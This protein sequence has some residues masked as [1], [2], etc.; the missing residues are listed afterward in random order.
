MPGRATV[1]A[2]LVTAL[3][4]VAVILLRAPSWATSHRQSR[5]EQPIKLRTLLIVNTTSD[6]ANPADGTCSLRGAITTS[7]DAGG[8]TNNC[9]TG[10]GFDTIHFNF[11]GKITLGSALP[12]ITQNLIIDGTTN[13]IAIDGA[14]SFQVLAVN[15]GA[16]LTL[17]DLSVQNGAT[18]SADGGGIGNAG[19]VTVTNSTISGNSSGEV[20]GGISNDGTATVTNSTISGNSVQNGTPFD[21]DGGGIFNDGNLT[22]TNSTISGNSADYGAGIDNDDMATVMNSTIS[23]NSASGEEDVGGGI[24]NSHTMTVTN[25]T[26]AGN[27][28]SPAGDSGGGIVNEQFGTLT[29][30]NS[31][32]AGNSASDEGGGIFNAGTVTFKNTIVANSIGG[33]CVPNAAAGAAL[34]SD[35]HNLSDDKTCAFAGTEDQNSA[36]AGLDPDGLKNNGGPTETVALLPTSPAVDAVPMSPTNYCTE[37]DGTTPITTDQRGEPRPDPEDGPDGP[38]D[39]GAFELQVPTAAPVVGKLKV[40]PNALKFS[41]VTVNTPKVETVTVTNAGNI[42]KKNQPLPILIE[43]ENVDGMP[44]PSPFSVRTRCY[45]DNL[46]PSGKGVPK[47]ETMCKISV[48]FRPTEA[49]SYSGTLTIHDN[50]EPNEMQTVQMT[51]RGKAA[52]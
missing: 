15:S 41:S 50:L 16:T 31:T 21:A 38:C 22:V 46:M 20:G 44:M 39:I 48:Q 30:T 18:A 28:A 25:S 52:K 19:T 32:I 23:G 26:I 2:L 29:V 33:N 7:N 1:I 9:G 13:T 40:S 34:T 51:G 11:S 6:D 45:D 35:G 10:S 43:M 24:F 4:S 36:A 37:V 14:K 3:V 5:F 8:F 12:A 17:N 27:T 49:V 42:K 47:T